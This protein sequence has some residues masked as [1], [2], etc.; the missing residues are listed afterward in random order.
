LCQLLRMRSLQRQHLHSIP[1]YFLLLDKVFVQA[2]NIKANNA[3]PHRK[4]PCSQ[5]FV[6]S[7]AHVLSLRKR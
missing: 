5:V 3:L 4:W 2:L 7:K 6:Q 1:P